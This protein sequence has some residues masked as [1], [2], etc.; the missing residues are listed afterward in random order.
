MSR[1]AVDRPWLHKASGF[2]C[3]TIE[4]RRVYLDHDYKV[5][6]R[7]LRGLIADAKRRAAGAEEWLDRPFAEL[8]DKF[9]DHIQHA[10]KPQTY[11][12]Y[13][14]RLE[15]ALKLLGPRLRTGDVRKRHLAEIEA[16][17]PKSL[18]PS[19][20]RDTL[21]TV[22]FVFGW[23][24]RNEYLDLNP[25]VGYRKPAG[26]SRS[27]IINDDEFQALLRAATASPAFQRVLIALRQTGCRPGEVRQLTWD[28]VDLK[29]G[30]WILPDHKT[31]TRQ[32]QP[33][34]RVIPLSSVMWKMCRWLARHRRGET[35]YVFLNMHHKPYKKDCFVTYFSRLR[36]RAGIEVKAGEKVVL[37]SHRHTFATE[38]AG[39]VADIELAELLG[40]TT[41]QM[42]PRYTH[43]N[44]D[45]LRDIQRRAEPRRSALENGA[46]PRRHPATGATSAAVAQVNPS[47]P[48]AVLPPTQSSVAP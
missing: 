37:Y 28:M 46:K 47:T 27:R 8:A 40:H 20:V 14:A 31:I 19:T 29:T 1:H 4:G 3:A 16:A 45:R 41:T 26:K 2:W 12:G 30:L 33:R 42:I 25:L 22:Q 34:P 21:A 32:R 15:R 38:R 36:E 23:A 18:S 5:A 9:L 24:V 39:A 44:V 35:N 6:C 17:L 43:L 7:K 11:L 13:Q 10:R 48:T